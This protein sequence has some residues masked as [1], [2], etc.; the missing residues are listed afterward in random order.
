MM[1][2]QKKMT[3]EEIIFYQLP[4][5]FL[6]CFLISPFYEAKYNFDLSVNFNNYIK[7]KEHSNRPLNHWVLLILIWN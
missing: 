5:S 1:I 6:F 7:S 4:L 3:K 2:S